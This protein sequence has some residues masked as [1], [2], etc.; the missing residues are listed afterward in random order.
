MLTKH[1][2]IAALAVSL[3]GCVDKSEREEAGAS[4]LSSH[5]T[6]IRNTNEQWLRLIKDGNAGA[7]AQLYAPDGAI[8]PPGAPKAEGSASIE[9]VWSGLMA[10]PGFEL[11]FQADDITV[12]SGGDM[13]M[14]RGTYRLSMSGPEGPTQDI[15]KYVVVWRNIEGKWKVAADIFNSDGA[16]SEAAAEEPGK[17]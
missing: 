17:V 5:E 12:A 7:V 13:A 3:A 2:F 15:G 9:K 6:A 10:T 11:T 16:Q 1:L 14:D 4:T 8:L